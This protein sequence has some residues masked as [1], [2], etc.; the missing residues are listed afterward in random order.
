MRKAIYFETLGQ[1][2]MCR[3]MRNAPWCS[4]ERVTHCRKWKSVQSIMSCD[5]WQQLQATKRL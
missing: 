1:F 2:S 3:L 4:N 5:L